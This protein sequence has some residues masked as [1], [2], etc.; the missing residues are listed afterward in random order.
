M[1][2]EK[3]NNIIENKVCNKYIKNIICLNSMKIKYF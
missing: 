1:Q 2:E 3:E